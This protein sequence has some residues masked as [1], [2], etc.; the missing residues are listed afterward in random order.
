MDG[1]S[2]DIHAQDRFGLFARFFCAA[3]Q[4][5]AT[6]LAAAAD[7]DLG[8]DHQKVVVGQQLLRCLVGL[9]WG[10]CND[11]RKYGDAVSSE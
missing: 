3:S 1:V 8:L 10:A 7:L 2:L 6:S 9:I 4:L 5:Y 11:S